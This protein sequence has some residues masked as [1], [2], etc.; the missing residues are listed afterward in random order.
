M[1]ALIRWRHPERGL[2][3]PAEF[4]P[5][6][7]ETGLSLA[8]AEWVL[9]TG[10][11]ENTAWEKAGFGPLRMGVNLSSYVLKEQDLIGIVSRILDDTGLL[12]HF[13]EMEVNESMLM[14]NEKE[15]LTAMKELKA[16][17]VRLSIDDF[18]SGYCSLSYLKRFPLDSIKIDRSVIKDIIASSDNKGFITAVVAMAHALELRVVAVGVETE[19]QLEFL[20]EKGC[21]EVQGYLLSPPM[22]SDSITEVM[23]SES[24]WSAR[25]T[26]AD[27]GL[28]YASPNIPT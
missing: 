14:Q 4:I 11:L 7:E 22:P 25:V 17:G 24:I 16:I 9:Y 6:A 19:D 18:G 10:C 5:V 8:I 2:V 27:D 28:Q 1:E 12:P 20:R 23:R 26:S 3:S 15:V 21:D 13:L